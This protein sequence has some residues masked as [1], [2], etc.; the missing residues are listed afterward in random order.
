MQAEVL[1]IEQLPTRAL[2]LGE[3]LGHPGEVAV[4]EHVAVE[5]VGLAGLLPVELVVDAVVEVEPAV[6]EHLLHPAEEGRIVG[7]AHVLDDADR[8]DLVVPRVG[9]EIA[10]VAILDEAAP[11]EPL[12]LD[13]RGRPLRLLARQGD[14]V[15]LHPVVLGGPDA[16]APPAA[17]DVEH[18]LPRL[19]AELTADQ[20]ELLR[21]R[22]LELAVGVPVVRAGVDHQRVEEERV[23]VVGDVVVV[24]DGLGVVLLRP[25]T[26]GPGH[27]ATSRIPKM[28]LN[29][30]RRRARA[31]PSTMRTPRRATASGKLESR[32]CSQPSSPGP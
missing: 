4:G 20:V 10:H 13:A 23:E 22:L 30:M 27:G 2:H 25:G 3:R 18:P 6:G 21:L 28:E 1:Q 5:E 17:T 9:R 7:N 11:L 19:Q 14:P 26:C 31:E 29:T 24:R 8:R 15:R 16:E 32:R 12:A